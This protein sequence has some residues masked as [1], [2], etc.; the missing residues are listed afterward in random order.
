MIED[1]DDLALFFDTDDFAEVILIS[2]DVG[3]PYTIFA[4]FDASPTDTRSFENRFGHEQGARP[5]GSSPSFRCPA[6]LIP[7]VLA[8]KGRAMIRGRQYVIY[9]VE[10]DGTGDAFVE[11]KVA[12]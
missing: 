5:S 12:S 3:E 1:A 6:V 8:G 7:K 9:K 2:P 4:V 11:V 10:H